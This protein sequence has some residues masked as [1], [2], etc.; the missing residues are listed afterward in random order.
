M[1]TDLR[2]VPLAAPKPLVPKQ[3]VSSR[4]ERAEKILFALT[5]LAGCALTSI[6]HLLW[7]GV[8]VL[9]VAFSFGVY[10]ACQESKRRRKSNTCSN[11]INRERAA[12]HLASPGRKVTQTKGQAMNKIMKTAGIGVAGAALIGAGAAIGAS[13]A[14]TTVTNTVTLTKNVPGPVTTK[15]VTVKVPVPGPTVYRIKYV[16]ASQGPTGTVIATY[17]GQGNENTG[18]FT[19]PDSGDYVV[20]WS[21]SGNTDGYGATN[22]NI[23]DVNTTGMMGDLPNDIAV[24][25]NGSTEDTGMSGTQSFNV[26]ATGNWNIT[27]ISAS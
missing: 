16:P 22:F 19:V 25:G 26:Q 27:V 4:T 9:V 11:G 2:N 5:I 24:S 8:A 21:Y 17:S 1:F 12:L 3:T 13:A 14:H 6:P 20:K 15:T 23:S 7:F 10:Q 18:S